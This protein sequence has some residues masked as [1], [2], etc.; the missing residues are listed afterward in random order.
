MNDFDE[1]LHIQ[2]IDDN[3]ETLLLLG[4]L[5]RAAGLRLDAACHADPR[6]ALEA[7]RDRL[8]DLVVVDY[9]MP[10]MTGLEFVQHL[11]RLPGGEETLIVMIT[12]SDERK[13]RHV[14]LAMGITDFLNKPI[15]PS[16]FR[17]RLGN[18]AALRRAH[19]SLADRNRWLAEEVALATQAIHGREEELIH[20]LATAAEFRDP[21]TGGHII[22]MA[23]YS[24]R[25]AQGI[26]LDAGRCDLILK[27]APMHDVGKLGTPDAILLKAGRLE[28]EE[29]AIMRR[30]PVIG[31]GILA[32]ST[33]EL[34]SLGAEIALTHHEKWDGSGYPGAWPG[35]RSP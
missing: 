26:G 29:M 22:R 13:L 19:L 20:R 12:A 18:L 15:D 17:A 5:V 8:P 27:A 33:S 16:E 9:L 28:P 3:A 31:H 10:G 24:Q 30:H 11:R 7:C 4:R 34:I 6:Q 21:E 35:R 23:R 2:I 32:G 25:I 14:A 1:N